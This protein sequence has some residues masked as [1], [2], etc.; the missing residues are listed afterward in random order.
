[1]TKA[2]DTDLRHLAEQHRRR[3]RNASIAPAVIAARGYRSITVRVEL[4]RLGF[5]DN[6]TRVPAL[7]IPVW[8]VAGEV[9]SY[10]LRPDI[11]RVGRQGKPVK[12]ELPRGSTMLLDTHPCIRE[13]LGD[14]AFPLWITEGI[15]KAD[16]AISAGLCCVA[17]LGVWNWRGTNGLGG[18]TAL[19]DWE[20][21]A[22]NGRQVYLA[23]DSDVMTKPTVF[24]ALER[25]GSFLGSRKAIV[26]YVYLPAG[27]GGVKTG[28]DD[29]LASGHSVDDLLAL[30]S[31]ELKRPI[32]DASE[33]DAI[34]AATP[35]GIIYRK[36]TPNG[37]V[38]QLL[39]NFTAHIAEEVI[40]DDGVNERGELEIAGE[41]A[42][43]IALPTITVPLARF[44]AMDW[45]VRQWGTRAIVAAGVGAKDR[46]REAIQRLSPDVRQRRVYEHPG[47][48]E[49]PDAEWCFLHAGGAIGAD[50]P[51][52]GV[53]VALRG[54][55]A[56][57][58]LPE[59]PIGADLVIAVRASLSLLD[60]APDA[61]TAALLA[62]VYRAV[63]CAFVPADLALFLV[64]PSG[65]Y[66]SELA[67]LAMQHV[68][69]GFDRLHLPAQWSATA[70]FL[71]RIA[72]DFKDVPLVVDD[73][74]PTGSQTDI[75]RLHAAADRVL[76][77][78]GNRG[79]RG[80]MH[81]DGSLRP[82]YPPRG[83]VIGTGEDAPRGHS[84][85]ARLAIVEVSPGDVDRDRLTATQAAARDGLLVAGLA[86][87][88]HW[89]AGCLETLRLQL[90]SRLAEFRA[91]AQDQTAHA[92]TPDA[93]AHLALG[94]W[95]FL[96][97]ATEISALSHAEAE[98]T[99]ARVWAA[100]GENA[101]RQ[102]SHQTGEAPARRFL[103]LLGSALGGGFA[104]LAAEQGGWPDL[105]MAWGWRRVTVGSG[106]YERTDWHPQGTRAGW[107]A[108]D[109]VYLDLE[110]AL[111]AAQR[112]GQA[113]GNPIGVTPK[114]LA[115]R[116]HEQG[117]LHSTGQ[118]FGDLRVRRTLE[119]QR[120]RVL[121]LAAS[122]MGLD[123]SGQP[124]QSAETESGARSDRA[125]N[126]LS[127][128]FS[129]PDVD[130]GAEESGQHI[131]P[132][133]AEKGRDGRDG[134]IG[135]VPEAQAA[136]PADDAWPDSDSDRSLE[137]EV[138]EWSA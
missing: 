121:H 33:D 132:T 27:P 93:V 13:R 85:R 133:S 6:Q 112:V 25:L 3:I 18:K 86:G 116:L 136:P 83:L 66:K 119:G 124:G 115:K 90:P 128:R 35:Q 56:R 45:P 99:F 60:L 87:Y 111:T 135:R 61:I 110:A 96:T 20:A 47:W 14:P 109:N 1:M 72:F 4:R 76:R 122:A 64:G 31:P 2:T 39:S 65:V 91:Q 7:L 57:I 127:G 120:R 51:V 101:S 24:A 107:I 73:F 74:A 79:G 67:A 70:N 22:L 78:V 34:Y 49:L 58:V 38:D 75:A 54:A 63:L 103:D 77:G 52:L 113:T 88:V 19:P 17:L 118:A 59:P 84:L 42:G 108:G 95:T 29:F 134:G 92:R 53:D 50:G 68:G 80:R 26:R 114:T 89:L 126:A 94:W 40:A 37:P 55:A 71:E 16:S 97:F 98:A 41:L 36:P 28:L 32:R 137:A 23:F 82:D 11:P 81:A 30:A 117:V 48:R 100:L 125:S 43:G 15:L 21:I 131:R 8:G 5:T 44:P 105:P 104:H 62:A 69:A 130:D 138:V 9:A 46:L 102:A 123:E 129:W 10:Q 106:E 12:Y